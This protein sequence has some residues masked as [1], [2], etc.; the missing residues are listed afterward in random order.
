M[1]LSDD[2]DEKLKCVHINNIN[3]PSVHISLGLRYMHGLRRPGQIPQWAHPQDHGPE[4]IRNFPIAPTATP[5][6]KVDYLILVDS[7]LLNE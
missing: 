1:L 5:L 3:S 7:K 4:P 2:P 6:F